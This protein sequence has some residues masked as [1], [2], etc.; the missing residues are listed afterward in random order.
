MAAWPGIEFYRQEK[1]GGVEISG[2][3]P[4]LSLLLALQESP[5]PSVITR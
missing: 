4:P 5:L 1:N 2:G 3:Y